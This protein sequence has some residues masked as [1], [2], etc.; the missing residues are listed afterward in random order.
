MDAYYEMRRETGN[1]GLIT[2]NYGY[3]RYGTGPHPV[4]TAAHYAA[5][6][7]RYDHGRTRYWEVGN[8]N[9]GFWEMGFPDRYDTE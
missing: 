3:A 8:E 7:V 5:D 9:Y 2:V 4:E 1:E 6:W